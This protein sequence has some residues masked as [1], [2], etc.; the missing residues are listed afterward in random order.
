MKEEE[1]KKIMFYIFCI[2]ICELLFLKGKLTMQSPRYLY[3]RNNI[4]Y[5]LR[6]IDYWNAVP[7]VLSSASNQDNLLLKYHPND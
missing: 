2:S 3:Q 7:V 4:G 1:K 6:V 5:S